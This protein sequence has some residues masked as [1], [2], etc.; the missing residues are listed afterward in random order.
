MRKLSLARQKFQAEREHL[1]IEMT[2]QEAELK[3]MRAT[4]DGQFR[5]IQNL[6]GHMKNQAALLNDQAAADAEGQT[7]LE[8]VSQ[9]AERNERLA[10]QLSRSRFM[11]LGENPPQ[12][13]SEKEHRLLKSNWD[14]F[15]EK[16]RE[17][18]NDESVPPAI[19]TLIE[20]YREKARSL[21]PGNDLALIID[22][23][24]GE[25]NAI[26]KDQQLR[27]IARIRNENNVEVTK[28]K[29]LVEGKAPINYASIAK[30]N[31]SV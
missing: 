13:A 6:T 24:F 16:N 17:Y 18:M 8:K 21:K 4:F 23:F 30:D 9:D 28:L 12:L 2:K 20:Q 27:E 10:K 5:L 31:L 22:D 11:G 3:E 15:S 7:V 1:L 25:T 14:T 19:Y 26:L 29:K